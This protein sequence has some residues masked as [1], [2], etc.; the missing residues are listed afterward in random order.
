MSAD[1]EHK[2]LA[3]ADLTSPVGSHTPV[4]V[5]R[6]AETTGIAKARLSSIGLIIKSCLAG[7]SIS[8]SAGFDIMIAGGASSLRASNPSMATL[9][10]AFTFP[11]GF[12]IIMLT[13]MEL[14]TS[15]MFV[16]AYSTMRRRTTY[17]F[18]AAGCLFYA[19]IVFYW[20]DVFQT[21]AQTSYAVTQAEVRVNV[22]W[23]YNVTRGIIFTE[24]ASS[25]LCFAAMGYHHSIANYFLV[26]IGMFYGTD[27]G[28]GNFIWASCIPVTIGNIIGGAFF[29]AFAM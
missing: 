26:L 28:M 21:E 25:L 14:C 15:N 4:E 19:G 6:L 7:I 8:L 11:T 20:A 16:M 17:I 1:R 9:V 2:T 27:F 10:S 18:N 29:G 13:N 23:G 22:N 3:P 12:V 24:S 5:L